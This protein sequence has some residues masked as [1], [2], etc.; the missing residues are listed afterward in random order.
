MRQ[1]V[2]IIYFI[3]SIERALIIYIL[4]ILFTLSEKYHAK[5][6]YFLAIINSKSISQLVNYKKIY[7]G[8][9]YHFLGLYDGFWLICHI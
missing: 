5:Y 7:Y 4:F 9:M 8:C 6:N 1:S 2:I 3:I